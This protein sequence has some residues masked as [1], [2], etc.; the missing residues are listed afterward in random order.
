M[1]PHPYDILNGKVAIIKDQGI[2]IYT[3]DSKST[4]QSELKYIGNCTNQGQWNITAPECKVTRC[5]YP[6][7]IQNAVM[8][9]SSFETGSKVSYN[10]IRKFRPF[11]TE[12]V[13]TCSSDMIWTPINFRCIG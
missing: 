6:N 2:V 3:C 5:G 10:C 7:L 8:N 11:Y 12:N 9:L 13:S 4:N 1:C